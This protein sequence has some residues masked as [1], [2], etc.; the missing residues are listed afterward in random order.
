V[1]YQQPARLDVAALFGVP[2]LTVFEVE[3]RTY[4]RAEVVN[5]YRVPAACLAEL[6]GDCDE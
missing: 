6:E 3:R 5:I 1:S 2:M 4:F